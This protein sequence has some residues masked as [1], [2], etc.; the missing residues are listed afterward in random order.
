MVKLPVG[1]VSEKLRTGGAQWLAEVAAT[2]GLV[3]TILGALLAALLIGW[4]LK[5]PSEAR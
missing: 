3:A 2:F 1:Q 4:L 5:A